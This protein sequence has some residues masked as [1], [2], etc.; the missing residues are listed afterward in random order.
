[1]ILVIDNYDSFT[2][3]LVQ[4]LKE[5]SRDLSFNYDVKVYR[6]DEVSLEEIESLN[7]LRIVISPGPGHPLQAKI[8]NEVIREYYR[9]VPILGVCL[10][11]Q[12]LGEI[13]GAKTVRSGKPTHGKT[14]LIHHDG[15]SIFKGLPNPFTAT[16]Y[17]SLIVDKTS[18]DDR[19]EVSA[20]TNEGEIMGI[21]VRNSL[22]EGVQFHPESILTT[23]GKML[24]KNFVAGVF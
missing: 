13:F 19:L 6:N 16:R 21:R 9:K 10:G 17:H 1:M 7:P 14:S 11:H 12:C 15:K 3:N 22:A 20:W 23:E 24:I 5:I 4:Y 18:V 8:S 2:F